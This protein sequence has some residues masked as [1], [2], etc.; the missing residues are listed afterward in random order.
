M[1]EN[2][3]LDA[4]SSTISYIA[5][6]KPSLATSP[7]PT[8]HEQLPT[9]IMPPSTVQKQDRKRLWKILKCMTK[10]KKGGPHILTATPKPKPIIS[11]PSGFVHND[12][13][14]KVR[15]EPGRLHYITFSTCD[16][17]G[18]YRTGEKNS[19]IPFVSALR[20]ESPSSPTPIAVDEMYKFDRSCPECDKKAKML[21]ESAN[22]S[23]VETLKCQPR[24]NVYFP[25]VE[26]TVPDAIRRYG[27]FYFEIDQDRKSE[28]HT[29]T[30]HK[31]A[32][33]RPVYVLDIESA[34]EKS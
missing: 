19:D 29:A 23:V 22:S 32:D 34:A 28:N 1:A 2:S 30:P 14:S 17:H 18:F 25:D 21:D 15:A 5:N 6:Q 27:K 9:L 24:W 7:R 10:N 3:N 20:F 26:T 11:L 16:H 33:R 13:L 31:A 4:G 12:G 8:V